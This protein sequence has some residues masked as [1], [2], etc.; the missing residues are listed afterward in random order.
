MPGMARY[1]VLGLLLL[2]TGC[3]ALPGFEKHTKERVHLE[4]P[5]RPARTFHYGLYLPTSYEEPENRGRRWPLL[6]YLPGCWSHGDHLE[7]PGRSGLIREIENGRDLPMVVVTPLPPAL[8]ERWSPRDLVAFLDHVER[9]F[10]TDPDRVYV[11]GV[12]LSGAALWET[13]IAYPDRIAAI[14]PVAG[15]GDP[16][17]VERMVDVAVWAF[18]GAL[19]FLIP[20]SLHARMV[21]GLRRAG[22]RARF[23]LIPG[24]FHGIWDRVYAMDAFYDWLLA[25]RRGPS[26]PQAEGQGRALHAD[27]ALRAGSPPGFPAAPPAPASRSR[28]R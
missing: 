12:S 20:P 22:G 8:F 18:H 11:T 21:D 26:P 13:A 24:A 27:G 17:G 3:V 14:A 25:Q 19:D 5:G 10:R 9:R 7:I 4:P 16:A 1:G 2:A 15:W 6:L 28:R 23:T